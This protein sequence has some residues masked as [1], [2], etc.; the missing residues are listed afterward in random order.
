MALQGSEP[1]TLSTR[2]S[3]IAA[4]L[5]S[6]PQTSPRNIPQFVTQTKQTKR[7]QCTRLQR[8]EGTMIGIVPLQPVPP[9]STTTGT[10]TSLSGAEARYM[11]P[12]PVLSFDAKTPQSREA[13]K[14]VIGEI[15]EEMGVTAVETQRRPRKLKVAAA[16]KSQQACMSKEDDELWKVNRF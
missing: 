4:Q 8:T 7:N 9:S 6:F 1:G 3:E 5:N 2:R 15:L 11:I 13:V 10:S 12:E 14:V 16:I